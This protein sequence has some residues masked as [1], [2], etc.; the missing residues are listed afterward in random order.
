MYPPFVYSLQFWTGVSW[1][2]AGVVAL[3]V[4]F[5]VLPDKY[6]F[7]AGAILTILLA[8]LNFIGVIPELRAR[9]FIK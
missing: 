1:L 5:G 3:L 7:D 9:G 8:V 4:Y 2:A 6:L